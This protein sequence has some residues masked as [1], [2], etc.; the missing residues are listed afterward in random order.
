MNTT[1]CI[2]LFALLAVGCTSPAPG[3]SEPIAFTA[4]VRLLGV[5]SGSYCAAL[6]GVKDL[7]VSDGIRQLKVNPGQVKLDLTNATQAWLAGT[8]DVPVGTDHL[9]VALTLDDFGGWQNIDQTAA[10]DIDAR[11]APIVF[12]ARIDQLLVHKMVTVRLDVDKSIVAWRGE[13]RALLPHLEVVY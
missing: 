11:T 7:A 4:D 6:M 9:H 12:D 3:A 5:D 10:G 13:T 8:V 2:P 1:K